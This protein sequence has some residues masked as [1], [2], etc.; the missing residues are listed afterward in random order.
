VSAPPRKPT[1]GRARRAVRRQLED[2]ERGD[3]PIAT[4]RA[5]E[6]SPRLDDDDGKAIEV[7]FPRAAGAPSET[8]GSGSSRPRS[9]VSSEEA[10]TVSA[11]S[12]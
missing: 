6:S 10:V 3:G 5:I 11:S 12:L 7:A 9:F 1:R 2:E 8:A 4:S